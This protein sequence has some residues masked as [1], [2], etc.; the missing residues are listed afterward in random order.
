MDIYGLEMPWKCDFIC[1][2]SIFPELKISLMYDMYKNQHVKYRT[3]Q[4][5]SSSFPYI[6]RKW[7]I[8]LCYSSSKFWH[9]KQNVHKSMNYIKDYTK[10]FKYISSYC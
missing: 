3:V 1:F 5:N 8:Q 2:K 7:Q 4:N 10:E 9:T 6:G